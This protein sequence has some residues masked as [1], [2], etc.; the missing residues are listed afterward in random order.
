MKKLKLD[1]EALSIQSFELDFREPSRGT[2]MA[3]ETD[4]PACQ[5]SVDPVIDTCGFTCETNY[6]SN[7]DSRKWTC[8]WHHPCEA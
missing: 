6:G 1:I 4:V 5:F 3:R 2:V 7:C 8:G